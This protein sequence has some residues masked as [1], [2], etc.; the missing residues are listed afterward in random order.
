[1]TWDD[2]TYTFIF[3]FIT[4]RLVISLPF[5]GSRNDDF[6]VFIAHAQS[7]TDCFKL[8]RSSSHIPYPP[9]MAV[10]RLSLMITIDVRIFIDC[11]QGVLSCR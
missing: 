2:D 3:D 6:E 4:D 11:N 8:V 10:V 9:V 1:M 7:T 5:L